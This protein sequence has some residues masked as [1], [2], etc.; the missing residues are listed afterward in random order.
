MRKPTQ[1]GYE[2]TDI[3]KIDLMVEAPLWNLSSPEF[4]QLEPSMLDYEGKC[5]VLATPGRVQLSINSV[6]LYAY[7]AAD[8]M[9]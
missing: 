7:D 1:E 3:P 9:T 4:S 5:V 2:D 6:T 8:A